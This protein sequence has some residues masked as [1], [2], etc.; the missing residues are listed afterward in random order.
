[1]Y[2]Q[3]TAQNHDLFGRVTIRAAGPDDADAIRRIAQ[4]DTKLPP[5]GPTLVAE[6]GGSV[7]AA[8]G[9]EV[10]E[11]V[12][13]PFRPTRDAVD[14]LEFRAA[15]IRAAR[16]QKGRGMARLWLGR[17]FIAARNGSTHGAAPPRFAPDC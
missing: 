12:A 14:L 13:D 11:V 16:E 4:L 17:Q 9:I 10:S 15:Q 8:G 3:R 5:A 7:V 2:S 6:V 1:M